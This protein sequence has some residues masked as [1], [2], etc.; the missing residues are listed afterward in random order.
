MPFAMQYGKHFKWTRHARN[1]EVTG[2]IDRYVVHGH[3]PYNDGPV[4]L[5]SRCNLDV[6]AH[7]TGI[8]LVAVFDDA[9]AGP[10]ITFLRRNMGYAP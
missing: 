1:Q 3:T 5:E 7:V 9:V 4:V 10:P 2:V 6:K 8:A